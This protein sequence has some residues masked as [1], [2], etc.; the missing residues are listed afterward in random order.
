MKDKRIIK[1]K[2]D[3]PAIKDGRIS[4]NLLARS[5][6][7][8]QETAYQ[9][10]EMELKKYSIPENEIKSKIRTECELFLINTAPGSLTATLEFP[11]KEATLFPDMPDFADT[12][13][14]DFKGLVAGIVN[15]EKEIIEKY[16]PDPNYRYSILTKLIPI[17]PKENSDYNVALSFSNE[18]PFS[19]VVRPSKESV[20]EYIGKV[21]QGIKEEVEEYAIARCKIK[22]KKDEP[23]DSEHAK[24]IEVIN[25]EIN[26][27]VDLRPYRI[28]E[29]VWQNKKLILNHEVAC[30][31]EREGDLVV[32]KYEPLDIIT[33]SETRDDAIIDFNEE[34]Y[35]L[36]KE[37]GQIE[38]DQLTKDAAKLKQMLNDLVKEEF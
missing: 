13:L 2:F 14:N 19:N 33:Y 12:V 35:L 9:I 10:G 5:F 8:I 28:N 36:W 22:Y 27:E 16:I 18:E 29:I 11:D 26:N 32:I 38:V 31:V 34:F 20:L 25:L 1:I 37:Y 15:N 23:I 3:G 30:A 17:I 21:E 4:L 6:K 7:R 24:I